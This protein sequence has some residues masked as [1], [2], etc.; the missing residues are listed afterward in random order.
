[1]TSTVIV[2]PLCVMNNQEPK[3]LELFLPSMISLSVMILNTCI[4]HKYKVS[5]LMVTGGDRNLCKWQ[6]VN[7]DQCW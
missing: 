1:M 4:E 6:V 3:G 7:K 5:Y 2:M